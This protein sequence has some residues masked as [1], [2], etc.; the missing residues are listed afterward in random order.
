[1]TGV[2]YMGVGRNLAYRKS[3][4]F[5]N[6]GF[7]SHLK[8]KSGDDD[9]FVNKIATKTNTGIELSAESFTRSVPETKFSSWYYQKKRHLTT[10]HHYRLKHKLILGTEI[11]S[12]ILFYISFIAGFIYNNLIIV[13]SSVFFVRVILQLVIFYKTSVKLNEKKVFYLGIIFDFVLPIINFI[14]LIGNIKLRKRR[15]EFRS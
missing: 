9:L 1:M 6:K 12:R 3:I 4:F 2:P 15:N 14:I 11:F 13:L 7:A 5:K 8:L 10:G